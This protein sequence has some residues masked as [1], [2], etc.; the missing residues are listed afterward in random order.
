MLTTVGVTFFTMSENPC[1][2]PGGTPA[3]KAKGKPG[4]KPRKHAR[5]RGNIGTLLHFTITRF[6]QK[7]YRKQS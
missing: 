2:I 5:T 7:V 3:A 1:A 4:S 6:L